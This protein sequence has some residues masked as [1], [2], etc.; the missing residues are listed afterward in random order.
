MPRSRD[1]AEQAM[2]NFIPSV[3]TWGKVIHFDFQSGFVRELL[4]S[5]SPQTSSRTVAAASGG[6]Q[7]SF[8]L[9]IAFLAHAVPPPSD[10]GHSELCSVMAD[11]DRNSRSVVCDI[12]NAISHG[13]TK[14]FVKEV[15]SSDLSRRPLPAV[16]CPGILHITQRLFLPG[17][18]GNSRLTRSLERL[19]PIS[20]LLELRVGILLPFDRL[21]AKTIISQTTRN[22]DEFFLGIT[23]AVGNA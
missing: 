12:V 22:D 13:F 18:Y 16:S 23:D 15:M 10:G 7:E 21:K 20:N 6:D 9:P 1:V 14:F 2:F 8:G 4:Q 11:A 17:I 3:C 5:L 19:H